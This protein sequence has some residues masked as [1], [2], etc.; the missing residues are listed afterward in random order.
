M[1]LPLTATYRLQLHAEFT[2]ADAIEHLDHYAALGVSH[3]YLSPIQTAQAGSNHGYDW[4]PPPEVSPS[5]GGI[6]GLRALRAATT[7]RG[8]GL[9]VDIVPN[10]T[11]IEDPRQN[12]WWWDVLRLGASSEYATYFDIDWSQD[13]GAEGKIALP[14]LGSADDLDALEIDADG[15]EPELAFYEHRFPLAPGTYDPAHPKPATSVHEEQSYRLVPWNMGVIGYRRFFSVNGLAG[16]RQ[17]DPAVYDATHTLVRQ[18]IAEDLTDGIRVDHPD[19]LADP[20]GYLARLRAD[21]GPDRVLLIEKILARSEP[22]DP[23][24]PVDGTTGYEVLR[25][26]GAVLVDPD[27][28]EPLGDLHQ[29]YTGDR[30]D[31]LWVEATERQLKMSIL[32]ETFPAERARLRRA[33]EATAGGAD[34]PAADDLDVAIGAV[35]AGLGVYRSDY[36]ILSGTLE[37]LLDTEKKR[38]PALT[39]SFDL[40]AS[41]VASDAE[42]RARLA[43]VCGAVTAK[44]VEDCLFYRTARLVSLQEVGGSPGVFADSLDDFHSFNAD[45]AAAWPRAMT[46][47]STHDTK[48]SEDVRAR[49]G[50]LSQI[51][52]RWTELV[53]RSQARNP[54]PAGVTG[55]FLRQNL[56]GVWP[57]DGVLTQGLRSRVHDYATKAIREGGVGTTWTDVDEAFESAVHAWLDRIFDG[58]CADD[59]T[60]LIHDTRD[61]LESDSVVQ[62]ALALLAPGIPDVY[63][64]TEWFDDSLVDPDNRRPVDY[65]QSVDHPKV[66]VVRTALHLR[67]RRPEVFVAGDYHPVSATGPAAGHV[68]AFGR[69]EPGAGVSVIVAGCRWT[70]RLDDN[71]WEHTTLELPAGTWRELLTGTDFTGSVATARLGTSVAI[72]E[73]AEE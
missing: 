29:R 11:G 18:L 15:S 23:S 42:S 62:K 48:R 38:L 28:E 66:A 1:I 67:R 14:V 60:E 22:L 46:S 58:P 68:V 52:E 65:A 69:G 5:L 24:L 25:A 31:H 70:A 8:I 33:I 26:V 54:A 32:A 45:R 36:P 50:F 72:L 55:L 44:S 64:G 49:I 53:D 17:E 56:F 73:R 43:Q 12:P 63:Q 30:G 41:A 57:V 40:I 4:V 7:A 16:L 39:Q 71:D 2:F 61:H 9:I 10:H 13:N 21:I 59:L 47:L 34:V 19:G 37:T 20:A 35:V 3:L 27:G 51:P 6:E